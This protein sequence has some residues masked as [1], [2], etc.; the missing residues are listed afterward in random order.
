[1]AHELQPSS[2]ERRHLR[3]RRKYLDLDPRNW[4]KL[5]SPGSRRRSTLSATTFRFLRRCRSEEAD[6]PPKA[7]VPTRRYRDGGEI[8]T[9]LA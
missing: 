8:G 5:I 2:L 7:S 1:M 3:R 6:G 9:S 4:P